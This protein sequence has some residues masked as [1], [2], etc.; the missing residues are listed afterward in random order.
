MAKGSQVSDVWYHQESVLTTIETAGNLLARAGFSNRTAF[1][2]CWRLGNLCSLTAFD[3]PHGQTF[4]T[5]GPVEHVSLSWVKHRS[6]KLPNPE[7][8]RPKTHYTLTILNTNHPSASKLGPISHY[9]SEFG[10]FIDNSVGATWGHFQLGVVGDQ[11]PADCSADRRQAHFLLAK[12]RSE[13]ELQKR[14]KS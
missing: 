11:K 8:V 2:N 12:H 3:E 4:N 6:G 10:S 5:F 14:W 7:Q 1:L 9:T 13:G